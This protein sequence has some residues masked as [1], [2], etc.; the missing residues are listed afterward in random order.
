M[1][2][3]ACALGVCVANCRLFALLRPPS[4]VVVPPCR[5]NGGQPRIPGVLGFGPIRG[6]CAPVP[7]RTCSAPVTA[8]ASRIQTGSAWSGMTGPAR[9]C[10]HPSLVTYVPSHEGEWFGGAAPTPGMAPS[11]T[12][13]RSEK[14]FGNTCALCSAYGDHLP[15]LVMK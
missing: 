4:G 14:L 7:A 12:G 11:P 6:P 5:R 15:C 2:E 9:E 1:V 13:C 10:L 3:A 8:A